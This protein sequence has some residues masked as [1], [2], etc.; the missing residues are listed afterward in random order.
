M[1]TYDF[2]VSE[3][4]CLIDITLA[5]GTVHRVTNTSQDIDIPGGNTYS[6]HAGLKVGARTQRID[7]TPSSLGF[8]VQLLSAPG[9][10][11]FRD[12]VR[13]RYERASIYMR[14]TS[15]V[16]PTASPIFE[17]DGEVR[18]GIQYDVNGL[19]S[20]DVTARLAIPR[21]DGVMVGTFTLPC[22]WQYGDPL[23]CRMPIFPYVFGDDLADVS[24]NE[25]I[26]VGD[27]R[28]VRFASAGDPTDYANV[29]LEATAITTGT[30]AGSAPSFS[31][32]VGATTA[33]GGVTWTTRNARARAAKVV[34]VDRQVLTLDRL[35]DPRATDAAYLNP[36]KIM[37]A[38]GEYKNLRTFKASQWDPDNL[39]V[40][41]WLPCP[42]AAVNDWIEI[43]PACD[44][45]YDRCIYLGN[46][47]NHGGFRFHEGGKLQAQQLGYDPAP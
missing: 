24:R 1:K 37:F 2:D 30:T 6:A 26:A 19:A 7:G 38:S 36:A 42:W 16:T 18:G 33:D 41:T 47:L 29:Y 23:T 43:A 32:T 17:F 39:T 25:T 28:R 34:A 27:R 11:R 31:S 20:F 15:Y 21:G 8:T 35:P 10:F 45:T 12:I 40:E 44:Q 13:G 14:S 22:G 9:P 5:D 4:C 3:M 46:V